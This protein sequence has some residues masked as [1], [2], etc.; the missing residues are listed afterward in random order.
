MRA[1]DGSRTRD[2]ELG[3]LALYQL[4]Y[5]RAPA[6]SRRRGRL[7]T[8]PMVSARTWAV[9]IAAFAVVGLLAY[10][11]AKKGG[12]AIAVGAAI[13]AATTD[14]PRLEGGGTGSISDF[15]GRWVLVNVW[16]SWCTPCKTESP[17]LERFYDAN[18]GRGFTIL[19]I[20]S[21]DLSDD[22]VNFVDRYDI[23]YPQLRDGNGDYAK[24]ELGTTGVPESFLINPQGRLVLH[25]LGPVTDRYL[26][27]NVTP[28]LEGKAKQ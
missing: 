6:N 1:D 25:S 8:L 23:S 2:L 3:K 15:E 18:H 27:Q 22:A 5:V 12:S 11:L 26:E 10:G 9:V 16:A 4:S 24:S 14:L 28:Y 21:N 20:D 19:G 7:F 13:P 17:V